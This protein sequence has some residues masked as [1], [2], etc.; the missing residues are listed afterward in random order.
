MIWTRRQC[1]KGREAATPLVHSSLKIKA[2][3]L[4]VVFS[5][6]IATVTMVKIVATA[7]MISHCYY[8]LLFLLDCIQILDRKSTFFEF[9]QGN[10]GSNSTK[11]KH[12]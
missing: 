3:Y 7:T 5:I 1:P 2:I 4:C 8:D 9:A 11:G 10:I 6:I 12:M